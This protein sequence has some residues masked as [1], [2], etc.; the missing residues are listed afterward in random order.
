MDFYILIPIIEVSFCLALLA[1]LIVYGQHHIARK[2][3]GLFLFFM[4]LWGFF[5][6]MMRS[7][8]NMSDA[9][10]WEKFVFWGILSA[11]MF[12][13]RFTRALTGIKEARYTL[14]FLYA[15]YLVSMCLIPTGLIV[16]DMQMMWYGK[17]PLIGPLF[18]LYVLSVYIPLI[19]GLMALIRHMRQTQINEERIRDQYII[20]GLFAMFIGGTT[21]YLPSLG[22]I[23]YPLGIIGNIIFCVLATVAMLR[24]NLLETKAVIRK[25]TA[26]SLVSMLVIGIFG[27]LVFILSNVFRE[28]MNPVSLTITIVAVFVTAALFQP[29]LSRIQR[30]VDR[31]FFHERYNHIQALKRFASERKGNLDL[32]QL[33]SSLV[34]TI[35]NA[36]GS[37]VVS[38]LLPSLTTGNFE[39]YSYCGLKKMRRLSFSPNNP[40][41]VTMKYHDGII[42]SSD[43]DIIPSLH[44]LA[45]NDRRTLA[46]N[47]VELL[48]ALKSNEHLVGILLLGKKTSDEPYSSEDRQLLK[49]TLDSVAISIETASRYYSMKREHGELQKAMDGIIHALSLVVETRDPYT[50]GH[51]RRVAELCRC[52]AKEMNLSEWD[53]TG[54]YIAGLLHDVGKV[55]VPTEI[56]S[57]SGN[58]SEYEFSLIKEHP[59]IGHDI[60]GKIDFPWPVTKAILQ[61]HERLNGTGYPDGISG[62]AIILEAR[63]LAVADVVEAISSHRP[64]RPS[65][66]LDSAIEEITQQRDILYD[67]EVVNACLRLFSGKKR[68]DTEQLIAPVK[69]GYLY[70]SIEE[71]KL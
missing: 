18:F 65:L 51:Q 7:S 35:A 67:S 25:G 13:Y 11:A 47:N 68:I 27:S 10:F 57:K 39:I 46:E 2:P 29:V 24:Y 28:L 49:T 40:V 23:I 64:Y 4:A 8:A 66:G 70:K 5:I 38:L 41:I 62:N 58:L 22:I 3:F 53:T 43:M 61:H 6:F 26:Y 48:L 55:A 14:Y 20:A 60:L 21:D 1:M 59:Y 34:T 19:L 9:L 15:A 69:N 17:A 32:Q 12:F 54:M 36:M 63:I 50:A 33:S 16:T 30:T 37:R 45:E 42:D 56:L 71:A 31:W 44:G 52:I